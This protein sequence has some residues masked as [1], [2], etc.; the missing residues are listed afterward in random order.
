LTSACLNPDSHVDAELALEQ[1]AVD[2]PVSGQAIVDVTLADIDADGDADLL[3]ALA[4]EKRSVRLLRN[5]AA[6]PTDPPRFVD[7]TDATSL[8]HLVGP[9]SKLAAADLDADG[10]MDL[11]RCFQTTSGKETSC[12]LLM[13]R[14]MIPGKEVF[15]TTPPHV[16]AGAALP[17][18]VDADNDDDLD[19]LL[20]DGSGAEHRVLLNQLDQ[21]ELVWRIAQTSLPGAGP[22]DVAFEDSAGSDPLLVAANGTITQLKYDDAR[23]DWSG[24]PVMTIG[25]ADVVPIPA[26]RDWR[27]SSSFHSLN[28]DNAAATLALLAVPLDED[29][30][31]A[32]AEN[33]TPSA[34]VWVLHWNADNHLGSS[35]PVD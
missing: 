1:V 31:E 23:S 6:L 10:R 15:E 35:T 11:L 13:N 5:E 3:L 32:E 2:L 17:I 33:Q 34:E 24:N 30:D 25:Y 9:S 12:Q 14:S 19:L 28:Q 29:E 16:N 4:T 26:D 8:A 22:N 7:A 18:V 27:A 21:G 20:L